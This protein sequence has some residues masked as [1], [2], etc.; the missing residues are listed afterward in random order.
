RTESPEHGRRGGVSRTRPTSRPPVTSLL[1]LPASVARGEG[2]HPKGGGGVGGSEA[3]VL[4]GTSRFLRLLP[5]H[6]ISCGPPPRLATGRIGSALPRQY[7]LGD[8][9]GAFVVDVDGEAAVL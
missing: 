1:V 5:L 9:V 7:L 8:S 2:D 4:A 6:H 3:E